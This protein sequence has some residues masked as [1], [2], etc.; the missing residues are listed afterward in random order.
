MRKIKKNRFLIGLVLAVSLSTTAQAQVDVRTRAS[1]MAD[2]LQL[3]E[4]T[5]RALQ[6]AME[7]HAGRFDRG[8]F[9]WYVA[10]D[11]ARQLSDA[12]KAE[13]WQAPL[14]R[15]RNHPGRPRG[16]FWGKG[17][18][19]GQWHGAMPCAG[20]PIGMGPCRG[21]WHGAMPCAGMPIGMIDWLNLSEAQRDSLAVLARRHRDAMR[22]LEQQWRA[23][24]LSAQAFWQQQQTLRTQYQTRLQQLLT[25]EQRQQLAA[26][27]QAMLEVLR[28][29]PEQ[30]QQLVAQALQPG[31]FRWAGWSLI[32]TPEQQE[33]VQLYHRLWR[34]WQGI[35][36]Q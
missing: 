4:A 6:E 13:F 16:R 30:Q 34:T 33:I 26:G 29:T 14:Y 23:G 2:R 9:F 8:G 11:R 15:N 24:T 17:H 10:A 22:Q 25:P 27:R 18:G 35:R 19:W 1:Q 32:L 31:P 20:M 5:A 7:R 3:S 28:L 21:Q 36:A 12:Q